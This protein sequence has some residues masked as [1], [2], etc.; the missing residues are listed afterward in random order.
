MMGAEENCYVFA[1][2]RQNR[3]KPSTT[4]SLLTTFLPSLAADT[5]TGITPQQRSTILTAHHASILWSLNNSLLTL[6]DTVREMQEE[7]GKIREERGRSLGGMVEKDFV[8]GGLGNV[9]TRRRVGNGKPIQLT[10]PTASFVKPTSSTSSAVAL[11][12]S[13]SSAADNTVTLSERQIQQFASENDTLLDSMNSTLNT[14]LRA[15]KSL[16]EISQLQSTL[17]AHLATQTEAIELLYDEAI[18]TVA[19]LDRANTQLKKAKERGKEGR[20]YLVVF[21]FIASLTLLFLDWYS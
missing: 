5:S 11:D 3:T 8:G 18:E 14:V 9:L 7:R 15:E 17:I 6:S 2:V 10:I 21:L 4:S 1:T 12:P 20:L 13:G 19:D 16:L